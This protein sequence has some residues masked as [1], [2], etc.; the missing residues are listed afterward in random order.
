MNDG[1]LEKNLSEAFNLLKDE[2]ASIMVGMG[3]VDL[4]NGYIWPRSYGLDRKFLLSHARIMNQLI[5][6]SQE[7]LDRLGHFYM[8]PSGKDMLVVVFNVATQYA[9][10]VVVKLE[11]IRM[12]TILTVFLGGL[13]EIVA[14][15]YRADLINR[16]RR[17]RN[18]LSV[19]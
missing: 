1:E 14:G 3:V 16:V 2:F 10:V 7:P 19:K 11:E 13:K 5:R 6:F 9:L 17:I 4:R 18:L 15:R 8:Y 12:G